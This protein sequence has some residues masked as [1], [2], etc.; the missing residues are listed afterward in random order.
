LKEPPLKYIIGT[1]IGILILAAF[2]LIGCTRKPTLDTTPQKLL[3]NKPTIV[4]HRGARSV[5]PENTLL[6]AQRAYDFKADQWEL[7]VQETKDGEL[8]V[9]HDPGL[10]RTSNV[11]QIFP[12]RFFWKVK[13]FTLDE[14]K[15]LDA[16][17][18]YLKKDPFGEI[19][20]G[21][22]TADEQ[23][24]MANVTFPT[25]QEALQFTKGKDWSVNIEIKDISNAPGDADIVQKTV[26]L[27]ETMGMQEH[28][29][30]SSFKIDYL[31]QVKQLNPEL[32]TA[33]LVKKMDDPLKVLQDTGADA[34]NPSFESIKDVSI[35]KTLRDAGYDVYVWTVND[36]ETMM[37]LINAGVSGV[38]TDYPQRM[39][40]VLEKYQ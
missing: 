3:Y 15:R 40:E 36:E 10:F 37:T 19:K 33:V 30:I 4:A 34:I 7:D 16:G 22:V 21:T 23:K 17:L 14:I 32:K 5:A 28:V 26:E 11:S 8:I 38:I 9:L 12:L 18:W 39:L 27:I 2:F 6:S 1:G 35:I 20:N 24:L 31:K 13:Q 29:I 25:L